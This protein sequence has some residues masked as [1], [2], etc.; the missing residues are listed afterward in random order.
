[1]KVSEIYNKFGVSPNLQEHM[2]RVCGI[3]SV[4]QK[5]WNGEEN[6]D[7]DLTKKMALIHDLGNIVKFDFDKY[8]EFLGDERINIDSWK[9]VQS[10]MVQKYGSDD[11]EATKKMLIEI[12]VEPEMVNIIFNKRFLNSIET[13][14]S[15]NL[16]LKVLYYADLRALPLNIGS[17]EER[18]NDIRKRYDPIYTSRP[19]FEDLVNACHEIEKEVQ[20]NINIDVNEMDNITINNEIAADSVNWKNVEV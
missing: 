9:K 16:S 8:P 4:I 17:L 14:K 7:W 10:E 3:V 15:D 13:E 19:D 12:G 11:N 20:K 6:M 5:H 2:F 18:L 1:M